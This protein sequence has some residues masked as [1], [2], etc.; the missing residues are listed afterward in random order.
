M[1]FEARDRFDRMIPVACGIAR[2]EAEIGEIDRETP[3]P[4][5]LIAR[6]VKAIAAHKLVGPR[7]AISRSSP[8]PP[9]SRSSPEPP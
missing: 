3:V 2:I 8:A 1:K 5:V 6:K 4:K 7:A 9:E